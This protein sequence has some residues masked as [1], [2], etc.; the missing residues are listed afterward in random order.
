MRAASAAFFIYEIVLLR[1]ANRL[2]G[3]YKLP[4]KS[5]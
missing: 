1:I 3:C 2:D 5:N 4:R